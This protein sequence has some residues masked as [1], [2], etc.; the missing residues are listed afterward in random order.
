[1]STRF[2]RQPRQISYT[3]ER[4][5]KSFADKAPIDCPAQDARTAVLVVAGQSN[6]ANSGGQRYVSRHGAEITNF[7]D[8]HCYFAQSPLLG[9]T[10]EWGDHWT[11]LANDLLDRHV[12]DKVVIA[13][14]AVSG[15]AISQWA[16]GN[17]KELLR[18]TIE[19]VQ[20]RYKVT[21]F[22]W[23]QGETDFMYG[24]PEQEYRIDLL[25]V[26]NSL[27]ASD[28]RTPV[29]LAMASRCGN[30][31]L[32]WSPD[33]AVSRAQ[34]SVVDPARNIFIGLDADAVLTGLDRYDDCHLSA[35][36]MEKAASYWADA[37][38]AGR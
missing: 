5:L 2:Y 18:T 24:T 35:S 33:N 29:Y 27:R 32:G 1:M 25:A 15:S 10:G 4:R 8:D 9:S 37:L 36:G 17:L 16:R 3:E 11:L 13:P 20:K 7:F 34:R 14:V 6:A 21:A 26:L 28:D 19:G 22:I 12:F 31:S 30:S 38:S 23:Y